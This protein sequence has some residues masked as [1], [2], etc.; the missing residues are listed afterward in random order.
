LSLYFE[1]N[2]S[3]NFE[4]S[5]PNF[6]SSVTNVNLTNCLKDVINTTC[7]YEYYLI[8][9]FLI[10]KLW[11]HSNLPLQNKKRDILHYVYIKYTTYHKN[12]EKPTLKFFWFYWYFDATIPIKLKKR[13]QG[14]CSLSRYPSS[15]HKIYIYMRVC[16]LFFKLIV[17]EKKSKAPQISAAF[18]YWKRFLRNSNN[19]NCPLI[20][21]QLLS[22]AFS[23]ST[24][25]PVFSHWK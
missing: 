19:V 2:R 16:C 10:D 6:T 25:F 13:G 9:K 12:L 1:K 7:I 11:L 15:C 8:L 20:R 17:T 22:V 5:I 4:C 3:R 14:C 24:C 21:A 23:N 18:G